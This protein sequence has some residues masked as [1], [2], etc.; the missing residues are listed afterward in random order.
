VAR[1]RVGSV[2]L[3]ADSETAPPRLTKVGPVLGHG[4]YT[5]S[6]MGEK[7]KSAYVLF[8][9]TETSEHVEESLK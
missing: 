1:L 6:R 3:A 5:M 4:A 8:K 2:F 9:D 7:P